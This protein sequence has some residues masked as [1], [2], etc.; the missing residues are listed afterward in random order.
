MEKIEK[1]LSLNKPQENLWAMYGP[2]AVK[3]LMKNRTKGKMIPSYLLKNGQQDEALGTWVKTSSIGQQVSRKIQRMHCEEGDDSQ[4][5]PSGLP[6]SQ[7]CQTSYPDVQKS[8]RLHPQ[9][10]RQ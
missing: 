3:L 1:L 9:R 4:V 10:S 5:S 2:I 7:H 6:L 8:F